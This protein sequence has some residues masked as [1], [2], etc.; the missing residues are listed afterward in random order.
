MKIDDPLLGVLE[1]ASVYILDEIT[2]SIRV[3]SGM[4]TEVSLVQKVIKE[5]L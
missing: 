4:Y 3:F 5:S 1:C 2:T